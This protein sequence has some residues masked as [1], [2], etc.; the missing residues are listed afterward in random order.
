MNRVGRVHAR[1][2]S[3]CKD[4]KML[5]EN[6]LILFAYKT[7]ELALEIC[8]Y[9]RL[10]LPPQRELTDDNCVISISQLGVFILTV[11]F[12]GLE[13]LEVAVIINLRIGAVKMNMD[14][15]SDIC[16][17]VQVI[18]L[19]TFLPCRITVQV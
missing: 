8:D 16:I 4:N 10:L 5:L 13:V 2:G 1:S 3:D 6:G 7:L 19:W 11:D 12:F 15:V 18:R 17:G 9:C 14:Y